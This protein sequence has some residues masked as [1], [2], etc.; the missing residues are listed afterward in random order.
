[1]PVRYILAANKVVAR[2]PVTSKAIESISSEL[3]T[4]KGNRTIIIIGEVKGIRE[5]Q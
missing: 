3:F 2:N 1:M 5:S 4:P